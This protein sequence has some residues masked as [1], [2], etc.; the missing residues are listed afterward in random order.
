MLL[1]G[2]NR[3]L[4]AE[5]KYRGV[6]Q[7]VPD[8]EHPATRYM[9]ERDLPFIGGISAATE[10][11]C[12][13]LPQLFDGLPTVPDYWRLQL[14]N[15]AFCLR[16]GYHSLF[17]TLYIA[18]RYE[19]RASDS[20][21]AQLLELFESSRDSAAASLYRDLMALLQPVL[22]EGLR[23]EERLTPSPVG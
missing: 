20:V 10:A 17:E 8:P 9:D 19:P 23:S 13:D 3:W 22:D 6:H 14:A 18:A 5:D 16:N 1:D 7:S 2:D 12:R 15:S 4:I 11:L 21:G